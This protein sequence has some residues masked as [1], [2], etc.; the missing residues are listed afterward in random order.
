MPNDST[1]YILDDQWTEK[2]AIDLTPYIETALETLFKR[3]LNYE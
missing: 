3:E 1:T 2:D